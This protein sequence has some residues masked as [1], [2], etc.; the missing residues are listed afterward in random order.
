MKMGEKQ[1]K[2]NIKMGKSMASISLGM[3]M[4]KLNLKMNF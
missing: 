1:L 3:K 4:V 2:A